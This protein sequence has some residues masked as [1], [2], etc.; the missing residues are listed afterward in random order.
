MNLVHLLGIMTMTIFSLARKHKSRGIWSL[1][2]ARRLSTS[3]GLS[4]SNTLSTLTSAASSLLQ[5]PSLIPKRGTSNT[6]PV[7]DPADPE[8][9]IAEV[10]KMGKLDAQAAIQQSHGVLPKWRDETTAAHRAFLLQQ[11]SSLIKQNAQD[12]ATIMTLEAGKPLAESLGEVNYA[13]SFLDYYAAEAIRPTGAGGGFLAPSPFAAST[14]APRGQIMAIQQAIG[15]TALITPWNFPSAMITRKVGPAL[16]AGCTVVV[17]PSELT[18][19]SA[20][21]LQTL[22][23]RAGIP[24]YVVQI[25]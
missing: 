5:D 16:A 11:W 20:M 2:L 19:L 12:L 17:K 23:D 14:G 6:F 3:D 24:P 13:A 8:S 1:T 15:V 10:P 9:L 22:A 18:P 7:Y 25:L 21:A 4:T